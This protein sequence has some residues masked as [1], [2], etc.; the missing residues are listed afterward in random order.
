MAGSEMG[1]RRQQPQD[2]DGRADLE[3]DDADVEG[4]LRP[5]VALHGDGDA[6]GDRARDRRPAPPTATSAMTNAS[7]LGDQE[8]L[9]LRNSNWTLND[10]AARR[11][12][13]TAIRTGTSGGSEPGTRTH[14]EIG[15]ASA[16]PAQATVQGP[17]DSVRRRARSSCSAIVPVFPGEMGGAEANSGRRSDTAHHPRTGVR[18][19][20]T[21]GR[22]RPRAAGRRPPALR[23]SEVEIRATPAG[24]AAPA[25]STTPTGPA[26]CVRTDCTLLPMMPSK[27]CADC[28]GAAAAYARGQSV[29][30]YGPRWRHCLPSPIRTSIEDHDRVTVARVVTI[31]D[32]D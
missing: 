6:D 16:S 27:A 24:A 22:K 21:L 25:C 2:A 7:S 30:Q 3:H 18:V 15:T 14:R 1:R 29:V 28:G 17:E 20:L 5:R 31:R 12:R 32:Q 13:N 19:P 11:P 4:H 23:T 10:S 8:K 26:G 9:C